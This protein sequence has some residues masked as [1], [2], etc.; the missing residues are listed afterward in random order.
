MPAQRKK[1]RRTATTE[2]G[3]EAQ[4]VSL[5]IDLAERQLNDGTASAQVIT[6]YLKLASSREK[7]EQQRIVHENALLEARAENIA[8]AGRI[9]ALYSEAMAAFR[10]YAGLDAGSSDDYDE[11]GDL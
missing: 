9:E 2:E 7:L 8:S 11:E 6:H 1:T 4:M 10:G 5:A 3:R